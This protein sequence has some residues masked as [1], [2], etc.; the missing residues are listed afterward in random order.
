MSCLVWLV[1]GCS[2]GG[3]G[4]CFVHGILARGDKVIATARNLEKIK[5]FEKAGAAV[6][7]LDITHSQQNIDDAISKAISIYGRIDVL[8]NNAAYVAIGT[9]EDL[10]ADDFQAQFDT[11]V[12]GTIKVTRAVLPHFRQRH[13]GTAVFIG[14]LSGWVGHP[15]VGAYAGSKHA[16]EGIVESLH[17]ETSHLGIRTL[18]IEPGRFRTLLL[19][20]QNMKAAQTKV[21]DY[22]RFNEALLAGLAREDQRQ[23]GDPVKLAKI[24]VDLVRG[25]GVAQGRHVPFR[26]PLGID[27]FDE[28]K[29]KCEETLKLLENWKDVIRSTD[30]DDQTK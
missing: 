30:H 23:P 25:E 7:Q 17:H 14:S 22:A 21:G 20:S 19:S 12:F 4:E 27:C 5:H 11:N 6:L 10:E 8:V 15:G 24:V 29:A 9:W 13:A 1:T 28:V 18:L 2:P 16:L 26:L 3:F